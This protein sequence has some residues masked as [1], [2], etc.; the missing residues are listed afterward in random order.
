MGQKRHLDVAGQKLPRDIFVSQLSRNYPHRRGN[1]ER[2][3][4]ALFCGR[5]TVWEAFQETIWARV[6][7]SQK[8]SRDNGMVFGLFPNRRRG[9]KPFLVRKILV[10]VQCLSAIL[11]PEMAA[12]ILWAPRISV[13][14]LQENLHVHKF[15]RFGVG[16]I[17]WVFWGECRFYFYVT[18]RKRG[19]GKNVTENVKKVTKKVTKR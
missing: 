3:K 5:E 14:F 19:G 17:L 18:L 9:P 2:G 16:G 8:L 15:P 13:F 6:I 4:K 10:S 12:P 11:G 1:L 7:A